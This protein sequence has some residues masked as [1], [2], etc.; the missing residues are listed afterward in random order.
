MRG[1]SVSQFTTPFKNKPLAKP[2]QTIG[3]VLETV[4]SSHTPVYVMDGKKYLGVVSAYQ[5]VYKNTNSPQSKKVVSS[6]IRTPLLTPES[7]LYEAMR[8]MMDTRLYE[9]PVFES[10]GN[11]VG[12]IN[13]D[14]ILDTVIQDPMLST[15]LMECIE[16]KKPIIQKNEGSI[17]DVFHL[18]KDKNVSRI[19]LTDQN[20]K[21]NG[22]VSR[23]DIQ[24]AFI[25]PIERQRYNR[26]TE[27]TRTIVF[28]HE[29]IYREDDTI[30]RY[31]QTNVFTL[32][33]DT[34]KREVIKQLVESDFNSVVIV[35]KLQK[36]VGF[37][38]V[39][40]L[41]HC[42]ATIQV[43]VPTPIVFKKPDTG[44]TDKQIEK[45]QKKV[46]QM[47]KKLSKIQPIEKVEVAV[48]EQKFS[49]RKIADF[50]TR[51]TISMKGQDVIV[52]SNKRDYGQ[53]VRNALKIAE[54]KFIKNTKYSNHR[55]E[56]APIV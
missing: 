42:L 36:P 39:Y 32:P 51:I 17:S 19:I 40:D 38:S 7:S 10:E 21:L 56:S 3:Q 30:D 29:E 37:L 53:S 1:Y 46:E 16:Y 34:P 20:G 2:D 5:S 41:V 44:V 22:I 24:I 26:P 15:Y 55:I 23:S 28:D 6:L 14:T 18:L 27:T 47:I 49:N 11:I 33:V 48:K 35:D 13:L 9:L 4:K 8:S 31:S 54:Q 25:R 52:T 12:V 50:E 43:D 45:A